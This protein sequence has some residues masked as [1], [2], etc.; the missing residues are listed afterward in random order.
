M[1]PKFPQ[2]KIEEISFDNYKTRSGYGFRVFESEYGKLLT[3]CKRIIVIDGIGIGNPSFLQDKL[4]WTFQVKMIEKRSDGMIVRG[5][6]I[7]ISGAYVA[8]ELV[9]L[10]QS[11]KRKDEGDYAL[12]FAIPTDTEGITYICQYS[13]YSAER[14]SVDDIYELG[15]P[16]FGQRE[17]SMVVFDNV[18]SAR[19]DYAFG[20]DHN[21]VTRFHS[22]SCENVCCSEVSCACTY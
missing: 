3:A 21:Y 17:T 8:N 5:A 18:F 22:P 16:L 15:N 20:V 9:V 11:A 10:P 2:P 1:C 4:R 7:N 6:K 13:P 12:A 14:E 19:V